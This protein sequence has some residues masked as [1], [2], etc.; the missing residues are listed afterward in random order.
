MAALGTLLAAVALGYAV[1]AWVAVRHWR[2]N[3]AGLRLGSSAASP[4]PPVT[5]LKPLCGTEPGLE[6][7]LRSFCE[8]DYAGGVQIV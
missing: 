3:G 7:S 8:Q 1:A 6:H 2:N 5:V 4:S